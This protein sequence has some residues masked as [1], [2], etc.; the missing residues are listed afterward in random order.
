MSL[1][2][3]YAVMNGKWQDGKIFFFLTA[4]HYIY[5]YIY[6]HTHTHT[7]TH[8]YMYVYAH[9]CLPYAF[10]SEHLGCFHILA[11]VNNAAMNIE[12]PTSL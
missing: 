6:I 5:I 9:T 7:N 11:V 10:V 2:S 3:I 8:T 4:E 1:R 12:V